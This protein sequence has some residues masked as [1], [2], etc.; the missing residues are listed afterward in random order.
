MNNADKDILSRAV[1]ELDAS[2]TRQA[3]ER[4]LQKEICNRV[5]DTT[6]IEPKV[7]RKLARLYFAQNREETESEFDEII[8]LYDSCIEV[9]TP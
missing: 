1:K 9:T 2:M 8:G 7:T 6:A 5:K 3:A 4:D